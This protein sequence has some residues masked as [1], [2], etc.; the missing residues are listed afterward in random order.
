M[1]SGLTHAFSGCSG[2]AGILDGLESRGP[3]TQKPMA[4]KRRKL[5]PKG[6][7][8]APRKA[9]AKPPAKAPPVAASVAAP[10]AASVAAPDAP[11]ALSYDR[12]CVHSRAYHQ[13]AREAKAE[14]LSK[15]EI[16]KAACQAGKLAKEQWDKEHA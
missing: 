1:A 16:S 5:A 13:A 4:I 7:A 12:K 11:V 2:L 9:P 3:P 10:V 8:K 6:P 15:E 14:G